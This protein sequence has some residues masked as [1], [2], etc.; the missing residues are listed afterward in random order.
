[1][2]KD[3]SFGFSQEC[4]TQPL[5]ETI[6]G[7]LKRTDPFDVFDFY[8]DTYLVEL[9]SRNN[10]YSKYP[11]T[12]VGFNKLIA[13]SKSDKEVLFF[14]KFTDGLYYHR[15]DKS[16]EYFIEIGGRRDRGR[17]E[18]KKYCYIPISQLISVPNTLLVI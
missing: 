9:K 17:P 18:Y 4:I 13:A 1:M 15:F 6:T 12:M 3:L 8:N 2:E 7:V 14:F 10:S 5:I 11:T 16:A